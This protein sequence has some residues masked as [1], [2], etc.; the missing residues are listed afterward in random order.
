MGLSN[1]AFSIGARCQL[2]GS[3]SNRLSASLTFEKGL[4][5]LV[6]RH[7]KEVGVG[8]LDNRVAIL[9]NQRLLLPSIALP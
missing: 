5:A 7:K 6:R 1:H 4:L 3:C 8:G 9:V 2:I